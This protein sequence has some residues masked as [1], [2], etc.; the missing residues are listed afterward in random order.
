MCRGEGGSSHSRSGFRE[1]RPPRGEE[2]YSSNVRTNVG[3][4]DGDDEDRMS[5]P[6]RGR[7]KTEPKDVPDP[8]SKDG[9]VS[10]SPP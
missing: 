7:G 6:P 2:G 3:L 9:T 4:P 1:S 8:G 10:L 5:G